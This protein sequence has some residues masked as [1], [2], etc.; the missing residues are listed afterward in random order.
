[1]MNR[2]FRLSDETM[3]Q[4][5]VLKQHYRL[6]HSQIMAAL[7]LM[8]YQA[9]TLPP[10]LGRPAGDS[11]VSSPALL[12]AV[13]QVLDANPGMKPRDVGRNQLDLGAG[14]GADDD[15]EETQP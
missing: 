11:G 8:E 13:R 15:D 6:Q 2:T 9:I 14:T 10:R 12:A 1:M 3:D 7:I 4:L 5:R